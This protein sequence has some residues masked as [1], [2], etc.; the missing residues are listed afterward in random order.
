MASTTAIASANTS[1]ASA[2]I[3]I[4][5]GSSISVW[6]NNPLLADE[7]V[8][9]DQ[10]A[11]GGATWIPLNDGDFGGRVLEYN[12]GRRSLNGPGVFR[13]VKSPTKT[14]TIVYYD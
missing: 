11:D 13:L 7:Y 2:A 5:Q 14:A 1:A 4:A 6:V 10:S 9:V 12:V 8:S 3:T